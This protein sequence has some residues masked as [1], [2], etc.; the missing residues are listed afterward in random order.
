MGVPIGRGMRL[1][2]ISEDGSV[3]G[4]DGEQNAELAEVLTH[5]IGLYSRVGFEAPWISYLAVDGSE[6]VG[7][8]SFKSRPTGGR[9]EIA[10]FT[11]PAF[12]G[13]GIAT[14]MA[15]R[16]VEIATSWPE[17]LVVAAQTMPVRNASH[18]ILEKLGFEVV[19]TVE[20]P[21]DGAVLEWRLA[22][23]ASA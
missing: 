8:C 12:E 6:A 15:S 9:V 7:V 1:L 3:E 4:Y 10:Y 14:A 21:E 19:E 23:H 11:F 2:A 22:R 13:R 18:R 5:T 17:R 16:L 20:H